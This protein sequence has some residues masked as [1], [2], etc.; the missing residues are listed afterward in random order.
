MTT[1]L[2][3]LKA[4]LE[5]KQEAGRRL[6]E[7]FAA[8]LP[9]GRLRIEYDRL[10]R[11]LEHALTDDTVAALIAVAEADDPEP[12]QNCTCENATM[13]G[14]SEYCPA[15]NPAAETEMHIAWRKRQELRVPL[16][17]EAD[18]EL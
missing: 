5:A 6:R 14:A 11:A 4:A 7:A 2:D 15:C 8:G 18:D 9:I 3:A 17:K 12:E 16:V 10:W 13:L 1:S